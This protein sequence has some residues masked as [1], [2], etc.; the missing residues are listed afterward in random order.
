MATVTTALLL[1]AVLVPLLLAAIVASVACLRGK[2]GL[3]IV[4]APLPALALVATGEAAVLDLP[5]LLLGARWGLDP[6]GRVFLGFTAGVWLAA[7]SYARSYLAADRDRGSFDLCWLLALAGNLG[8]IVAL[9]AISF[10]LCFA[11]MSIAAY[12]L[13]IHDRKPASLRAG[14][15]Y[16]LMAVFAEIVLFWGALIA[17][18][19]TGSL[20][21]EAIHRQLV[22]TPHRGLSVGLLLLGFGIKLGIMPVHVW[23]PLAHPAAPTPASAV[24]SGAMI[25]AGLLGWMR[26]LPPGEAALYDWGAAV[27]AIGLVT[28]FAGALIGLPQRD[29]KAALAYSSVS[30]MG[31][32]GALFGVAL[33]APAA[34]GATGAALVLFAVHHGVA[35][36]ALFLG[37]GAAGAAGSPRERALAAAGLLVGAGSLAGLPLTLG[38]AAKSALK[39]AGETAPEPWATVLAWLLPLTGVTTALLLGRFLY[40][41][42][43][44]G[45]SDRARGLPV[46]ELGAYGLLVLAIPALAAAL[47]LAGGGAAGPFLPDLAGLGAALRPPLAAAAV[48]A[49][50]LLVPALR[51]RVRQLHVPAGD[52]VAVA[53]RVA[54]WCRRFPR[55]AAALRS[56]PAQRRAG[57]RRSIADLAPGLRRGERR[58]GT[59]EIA[60]AVGVALTLAIVGL[61]LLSGL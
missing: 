49:V 11:L 46:P 23:L 16:I 54:R 27:S 6:T 30:Q 14:R 48:A 45:R 31:L 2:S 52:A 60:G 10:L 5:W 50:T 40:L 51:R 32:V 9:D 37:V 24:L 28:A 59:D 34:Q 7:G 21:L 29:A 42:W 15:I 3:L 26:F 1:A 57:R 13:I 17:V 33:M 12:G 41:A 55:P 36:A 47:A 43:P 22:H 53:E 4:L 38:F 39:A 61:A 25:K 35:K 58:L 20:L 18:L 8:L 19:E 44:H 56:A